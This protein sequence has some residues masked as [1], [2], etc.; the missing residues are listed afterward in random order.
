MGGC[1]A[2]AVFLVGPANSAQTCPVDYKAGQL[3]HW[4]NGAVIYQVFVR[5]FQDSDGDGIGDFNG[6]ISRLDYLNDGDPGT[7]TDLGVDAIWMLPITE[8]PSYHGYDTLNYE[9]VELDYGTEADFDRLLEAAHAR[10]IRLIMDLVVN[11]TSSYHP[12]FTQALTSPRDSYHDWY[13][14]RE[15]DPGWTQPWSAALTWHHAKAL[16]LYYYGLF[17]GGMPDLNFENP[18]VRAEMI[19]IAKRWLDRGLDGFRLDASRHI[20]EAGDEAKAGGS[21]ETHAWWEEFA[22][23]VRAEHPDTFFVGENWTTV[24]EVAP[25]FGDAP[26]TQLDMNFNFDLAAAIVG[27]VRDDT[28]GLIQMTLCDVADF[29]PPHALDGIFLTNHDMIRVATQVGSPEKARFAASILFTL[30]G[31]PLVYYGEEIGLVN[32]PGDED[33]EKRTPMPWT[34]EGGFTAGTPWKVNRK[35]DP[36]VNVARQQADPDSLWHHY[37]RLIGLRHDY[38]ALGRGG[39]RPLEVSGGGGDVIAW[40]RTHDDQRLVVIANFSAEP[41]RDVPVVVPGL[42]GR[43]LRPVAGFGTAAVIQ[44]D[45]LVVGRLDG[46]RVH[47]YQVVG[48]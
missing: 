39:Y 45:Q 18:E 3:D 4:A 12:W 7:D 32:G 15:D 14:W 41:V 6:L 38:A 37:R 28:P 27:A 36:G 31:V 47:I 24:E 25:F 22:R 20:I 9:R 42:E 21:P 30:P 1:L 19:G 46:R 43:T 34:D 5:S 35:A 23:E 29:Y 40:E 16:D 17:W 13:V 11:H 8:S 26:F 44:G 2:A 33:P 10:G 48:G